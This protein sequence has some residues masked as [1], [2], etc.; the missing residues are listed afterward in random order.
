MIVLSPPLFAVESPSPIRAD[1]GK[2][3]LHGWIA[4]QTESGFNVRLR[5][6]LAT[7]F[8][9]QTR[10]SRPD[11]AGFHPDLP[12]AANSGFALSVHI[13]P[14]LHIGTL[15]Y[16]ASGQ[17][18][19]I[20]FHT[21]S[22]HAGL[23]PLMV[24]LE[25]DLPVKEPATDWR[26]HGW[27][28]HPQ[29]EIESL[30]IQFAHQQAILVYG[31]PRPD[32]A[33][34]FPQFRAAKQAGFSGQLRLEP[35]TGPV[36]LVARL[37]NGSV[38]Q[39]DLLPTLDIPNRQL[40]QAIRLAE[41]TRAASIRLP[42]CVN[43]EVSITI[44]IYNQLDLTLGCLESLAKHVGTTSFEVII[45][46]DKSAPHVPEALSLVRN[47][48]LISNEVNQGFVLNCNRGAR[49]S[50]GKYVLMLNNDTEVTSGW[51]EAMVNVFAERPKTGAVGAK[52][53]YPD[54]RLQEAGGVIWE[55]GSGWNYGKG[56]DP[57]RPEYN[58]LRQA[59]YCSGA[60]LLVS[61][62]LFLELGGF[63]KRYQPAY[64]EDTDLAFAIR[65][66]GREVY[67]QPA[68]RV[69]HY[70]GVSSGTD[71]Q[72]GVKR[73]QV[74]NREKF[75][76]KWANVLRY[77]GAD[78][79][80]LNVARDRHALCRV[81]VLDACALTPDA[82]S[83]S[84]R[85][86]N[87]LL[88]LARR[89][90]KV[91]FAA[92]NLQLYEPY[93]TQLRLAG[94]EHLGVPHVFDLEQYLD[95][96][97]YAFDVIILSRKHVA[98]K[99]MPMVRKAAPA[100]CI[101][102]DTVDLMHLRLERQA[103]LEQ[104]DRLRTEAQQ[105]K[106]IE[107]GLCNQANMVFVVSPVEAK[108]LAKHI[109]PGK[110][111]LVSNI[112]AL[113]PGSTGFAERQGL[114]FV[115][116]FQHPPNVDAVEFFLDEILPLIHGRLPALEIHIVGSNLPER[117][118]QRGSARIHMH[119]FVPDL[120]PLYERVRLTVAPL[121]Y[122]AGVKGKVNQSMAHGVPVVATSPAVEGMH[123]IHGSD[124]L[125][126][127]SAHDFADAI[128]QLHENEDL[129]QRIAT[130]GINNI[131][132]HFSFT[133]VEKELLSALGP[134]L[135]PLDGQ[136]RKLPR[137]PAMPYRL[138]DRISFGRAGDSQDY[139]REGWAKPEEGSCW[140][141]GGKATLSLQLPPNSKPRLVRALVYPFLAPP[142]LPRQRLQLL[143]NGRAASPE[144]IVEGHAEPTEGEWT[145]DPSQLSD[146][147]FDL[148][149]ICPDATSPAKLG[150]SQ[151]ERN[152]SFAF[153]E[154]T[155]TDQTHAL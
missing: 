30:S 11:V 21:L 35:G 54:G 45:I 47:L 126:A 33:A 26:L 128:V 96:N 90:A 121:R 36:R 15:E 85:M 135:F 106:A 100:A 80:L 140:L 110:I 17:T 119:G 103:A 89:G 132:S 151:D 28:F 29:T 22:I 31:E 48:K 113:Y 125:V 16:Q 98:E 145:L 154:L 69:I 76:T 147:N 68:A 75:R 104:S 37:A 5:L 149:F 18:E 94:I 146:M 43:P 134:K 107:L 133:A 70:E 60:C 139:A 101:V 13:P 122:G 97:A 64:Y 150:A 99:F 53:V 152:L 120:T 148:T 74:I 51:L 2:L 9:C 124:V 41:R 65:A 108:L 67:F 12:G 14:G 84:L 44:P 129:W 79:S 46:D 112:H 40:T 127:D 25:S 52:L 10:L 63:D 95:A 136:V 155:I 57:S 91:T 82:D 27:C 116:G 143:V 32:V 105:S 123:L 93:S 56:D 130:G 77:H 58:Y 78:S 7:A 88:M 142:L 24:Q 4:G 62:Q 3:W 72:T 66:A 8:D 6:G 83:G 144:L 87:L 49:E 141:V 92:E 23:S 59:D 131:E 34:Q 153:I 1:E 86:F 61:R 42:A 114:M 38:L 55:D 81:L 137:R 39:S 109:P 102:F 115:G 138:G 118:R 50:R 71:T 20:P 19:W 73:H 117:L 111:A